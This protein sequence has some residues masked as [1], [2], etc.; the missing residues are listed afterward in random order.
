MAIY[1][2]DDSIISRGMERKGSLYLRSNHMHYDKPTKVSGW[3]QSREA[4]PKDYDVNE[5]PLG[6]KN[7]SQSTYRRF[8]NVTSEDWHTTTEHQLSQVHLKGDYEGRDVGKQMVNED[9]LDTLNLKR[10]TGLPDSGFGAVLPHHNKPH[11]KM[12]LITTYGIDYMVPFRYTTFPATLPANTCDCHRKTCMSW[13][14]S[15]VSQQ[16]TPDKMAN[17]LKQLL[18]AQHAQNA[19]HQQQE[20]QHQQ[21]QQQQQMAQQ[22]TTKLLMQQLQLQQQ[23]LQDQCRQQ[24]QQ[25]DLLAEAIRGSA[26]APTIRKF[27]KF[28]TILPSKSAIPNL[29][30]QRTTEGMGET[31]GKMK[32]AYIPIEK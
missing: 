16:V 11:N 4:E 32:V 31:L 30:T 19:Q 17:L 5:A 12:H 8:G 26:T 24:Q 25:F 29:Q 23:A 27:Q 7:L 13:V 21:M 28:Q 20:T 18:Q 3:H 14:K 9:N 1:V 6:K 10:Q 22:E 15:A 2:M